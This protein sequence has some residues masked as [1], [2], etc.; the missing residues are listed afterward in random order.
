M[1]QFFAGMHGQ[2]VGNAHVLGAFEHLRIHN[3]GND[4]LILALQVF[5]QQLDQFFARQLGSLGLFARHAICPPLSVKFLSARSHNWPTSRRLATENRNN[6]I[7]AETV[8]RD[9]GSSDPTAQKSV[10]PV[11]RGGRDRWHTTGGRRET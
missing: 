2:F 9:V 11:P 6:H 5:V 8:C 1:L 3:V 7:I 4:G 10:P